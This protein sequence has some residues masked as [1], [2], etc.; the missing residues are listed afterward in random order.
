VGRDGS[1]TGAP[2][3]GID[4]EWLRDFE[5]SLRRPLE[6]RF[7]FAFISTRKP[8]IDDRPYRTFDTMEDYRRWC[9]EELP[10]FLGYG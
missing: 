5:S 2:P 8:V 9:R 7:D 10:S 3:P 4:P 6:E 1:S